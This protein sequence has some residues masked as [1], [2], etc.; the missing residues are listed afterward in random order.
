MHDAVDIA[1]H[2][3]F[4][5]LHIAGHSCMKYKVFYAIFAIFFFALITVWGTVWLMCV[6]VYPCIQTVYSVALSLC[7]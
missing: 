5:F 4:I 6:C 7:E 3:F 2:L 1:G